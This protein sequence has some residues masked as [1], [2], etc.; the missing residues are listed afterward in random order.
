[1]TKIQKLELKLV[2]SIVLGVGVLAAFGLFIKELD[3]AWLCVAML[4]GAGIKL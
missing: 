1:M 4:L 3:P 2:I